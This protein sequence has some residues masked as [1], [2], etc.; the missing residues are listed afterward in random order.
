[1][2]LVFSNISIKFLLASG[3]VLEKLDILLLLDIFLTIM[4]PAEA[5]NVCVL[6]V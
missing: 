6:R 2:F 5:D 1:M 3:L 4:F